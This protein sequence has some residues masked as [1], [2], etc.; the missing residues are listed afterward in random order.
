MFTLFLA[1]AFVGWCTNTIAYMPGYRGP[2]CVLNP[3]SVYGQL[4]VLKVLR[5]STKLEM[6]LACW[7]SDSVRFENIRTQ[8]NWDSFYL[9][10]IVQWGL[11]A[12]RHSIQNSVEATLVCHPA[13]YVGPCKTVMPYILSQHWPLTSAACNSASLGPFFLEVFEIGLQQPTSFQSGRSHS[14]FVSFARTNYQWKC[15]SLT[16]T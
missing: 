13:I 14:S 7:N 2:S 5:S 12:L 10:C 16:E 1:F 4:T 15:L 9:L 3:P 8:K 6:C 11:C